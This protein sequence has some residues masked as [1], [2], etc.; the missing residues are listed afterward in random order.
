MLAR[1]A[2]L[3]KMSIVDGKGVRY[4]VFMQGCKHNCPGCQNPKTHSFSGGSRVNTEEIIREIKERGYYRGITLSGGDPFFQPKE[5]KE[6]ADMVHELGKDVWCYTGFTFE[7]IMES[8]DSDMIALLKSVDVLVDGKF[9][10]EQKTLEKA[11]RGSS[12]QRLINIPKTLEQ[13]E[14]VLE[15]EE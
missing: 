14:I 8:K 3:N 1:V 5:A 2:G 7:E 6:L 13:G 12:N 4:T 11:F 15:P 9:I 10:Q